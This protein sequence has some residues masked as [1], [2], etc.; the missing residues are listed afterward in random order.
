[1][2]VPARPAGFGQVAH[3]LARALQLERLTGTT[4]E[5]IFSTPARTLSRVIGGAE[6]GF[7]LSII[8]M[9]IFML[10]HRESA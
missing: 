7:L 1:M 5:F 2:H 4:R 3:L 9:M 10:K 8:I 6:A